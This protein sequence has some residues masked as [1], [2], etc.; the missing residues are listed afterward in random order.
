MASISAALFSRITRPLKPA[1]FRPAQSGAALSSR[2]SWQRYDGGGRRLVQRAARARSE[3]LLRRAR[4]AAAASGPMGPA[5]ATTVAPPHITPLLAPPPRSPPSQPQVRTMA[6]GPRTHKPRKK[7]F[8]KF[9]PA[10]AKERRQRRETRRRKNEAKARARAELA[11]D[12]LRQRVT[13]RDD[14]RSGRVAPVPPV[15]EPLERHADRVEKYVRESWLAEFP[16][17]ASVRRL[18]RDAAFRIQPRRHRTPEKFPTA[19]WNEFAL[20]LEH[21]GAVDLRNGSTR[22]GV[23]NKLV[24]HAPGY[25]DRVEEEL[26]SKKEKPDEEE[27]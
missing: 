22:L 21:R 2:C 27:V 7:Q 9:S 4:P 6:G 14:G 12:P 13:T 15:P 23:E 20:V 18:R 24:L 25:W 10:E 11:A 5:L 8:P 17:G 26:K 19:L 16:E 1:Q 3:P